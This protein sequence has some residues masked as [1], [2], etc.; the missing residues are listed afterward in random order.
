MKKQTIDWEKIFAD[1][2][3]DKGLISRHIKNSQNST[4]KKKL[5]SL[6]IN[7][8]KIQRDI[9]PKRLYKWQTGT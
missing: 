6:T 3:S 9:T 5:N 8:H 2:I 1:D 7:R 4:E